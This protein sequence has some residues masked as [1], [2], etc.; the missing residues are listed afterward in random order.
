MTTHLDDDDDVISW[1]RSSGSSSSSSLD[2]DRDEVDD[3][4]SPSTRASPQQTPHTP[5]PT[6][7]SPP[8]PPL[9]RDRHY[10]FD[11]MNRASTHSP[12]PTSS[13]STA[14]SAIPTVESFRATYN[15]AAASC[16][17]SSGP[18]N[19]NLNV[20]DG[21]NANNTNNN[22]PADQ[23]RQILLLMLLGQVCALHDPT[24]R[25]FTAHVLEL[26]ERGILDRRSI[27][28]LYELGLVPG[29]VQVPP[30]QQQQPKL[31]MAPPSSS[32]HRGDEL[33]IVPAGASGGIYP[34]LAQRSAEVSA[35]RSSL[36]RQEMQ[37]L[38]QQPQTKKDNTTNPRALGT[39]ASAASSSSSFSAEQHPLSLS[40]YQREFDQVRL[41]SSGAFG[42]V[43][44]STNKM[45]GRDYAVKRVPFN[46]T[47][48]S[49]DS[50]QQV[51]R[52]VQCLAVC[53]HQHVVRY[54]TSWLEPSWMTGSGASM[55]PA[56]GAVP[57]MLPSPSPRL[58]Q[59]QQQQPRQ[60]QMKLLTHHAE[61]FSN[62]ILDDD[63]L[64]D[65]VSSLPSRRTRPVSI[66]EDS[67]FSF[68]GGGNASICSDEDYYDD[69]SENTGSLDDSILYCRQ[70]RRTNWVE[71]GAGVDSGRPRSKKHERNVRRY[72]Y[73]IC[74]FIQMQLCT[75]MTLA[76]WIRERNRMEEKQTSAESR[77]ISSRIG[78]VSHIFA[79]VASG[80]SH[81]HDKVSVSILLV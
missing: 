19:I 24:P 68:D 41:L 72:R 9:P 5:H 74:M 17:S 65:F 12:P 36:E 3:A 26:F 11:E 37:E 44:Q 55:S 22:I 46:A 73:Q 51:L 20:N 58:Q 60:N 27:G 38:Q 54:Y 77:G 30:P 48:Y 4:R 39:Q 49:R 71:M 76:D 61:Q 79:Q 14:S 6:S 66:D 18:E 75:P 57:N 78:A 42:H 47:G 33:A 53:D 2:S 25:T 80:L 81:I 13:R 21:A 35:I 63:D 50:L 59:Y 10:S 34:A 28:F 31:L 45:D 16:A 56:A 52:E 15:S 70:S 69:Y 8:P 67:I 40:R 29:N 1:Q 7:Q 64:D 32:D 23:E 62:S 43:Y